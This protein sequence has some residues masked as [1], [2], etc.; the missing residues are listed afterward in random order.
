MQ[1]IA[2]NWNLTKR[3]IVELAQVFGTED[4]L[5]LA[6]KLGINQKT[7]LN[8]EWEHKGDRLA[9]KQSVIQRWL[10]EYSGPDSALV[11]YFLFK[12]H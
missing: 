5:K 3:Q 6:L 11:S 10:Q 1:G 9:Y 4:I 12:K 2:G 7:V 8:L